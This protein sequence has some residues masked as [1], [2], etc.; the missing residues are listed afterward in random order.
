MLLFRLVCS[1]VDAV[2]GFAL[3]LVSFELCALGG[4]VW[5]YR[6]F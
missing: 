6:W 2:L 1:W 5:L 4:I 3:G